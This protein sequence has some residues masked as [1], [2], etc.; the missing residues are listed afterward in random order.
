MSR[1]FL[2]FLH[3]TALIASLAVVHAHAVAGGPPG[4]HPDD[5][6]GV[7]TLTRRIGDLRDHGEYA[8]AI[9][10]GR[11]AV[12]AADR[13]FGR[14]DPRTGTAKRALAAAYLEVDDINAAAPL[15]RDAIAILERAD[16]LDGV[17]LSYA[18]GDLAQTM[19]STTEAETLY[20]RA[21]VLAE[22]ASG[23]EHSATAHAL[24]N[25]GWFLYG[26]D[27]AREAEPHMRRALH[28]RERTKGPGHPLTAQSL[29]TLG[30]VAASL[31]D[32]SIAESL[33]RRSLVL[34]RHV[35][36]KGHPD[37]GES[38]SR[39]SQILLGQGK[40]H[41]HEASALAA[42]A[43]DIYSRTYGP[44]AMRT[45]VAMHLKADT[46]AL[47]GRQTESERVHRDLLAT[48]ESLPGA[49]LTML[50]HALGEFGEHMLRAGKPDKA[51]EC[52]RRAVS[53]Q[54]RAHGNDDMDVIALRQRLAE[55]LYAHR[56]IADAVKEGREI[57]ALL[58]RAGGDPQPALGVAL[59][60][61]AKYLL[62][63]D[64]MEESRPL[65]RR[66]VS[67]LEGTTSRGSQ[68][69]LQAI[70]L[71]AVTSIV[72][73]DLGEAER[74]VDDGLE[75]AA[76]QDDVRIGSVAGDLIGLRAVIFRKTGRLEEAE[77][78]EAVARQV[79]AEERRR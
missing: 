23:P 52:Y 25:L 27:R 29:C 44:T 14:D 65:L 57:V 56:E 43:F 37:V 15:L 60:S 51:V 75:R 32:V 2:A 18:I 66:S 38:C 40:D 46:L 20:R 72:V 3:E 31:G 21:L 69:T 24:N 13:A 8:K 34:R 73:D 35:L 36:P 4:I 54:R 11:S 62:A 5:K 70:Y 71:L 58:E 68:E 76:A 19:G 16:P 22:K 42:E 55:A 9:E 77:E 48:Y 1:R 26:Q 6:G 17:S 63:S 45:L 41:A 53:L 74:L 12:S 50:A 49:D 28:I 39:L 59:Y 79:E 61:L 78:A 33:V 64:G 10:V 30:A 7:D 67:V 47:L